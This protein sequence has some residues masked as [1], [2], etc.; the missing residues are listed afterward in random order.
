M[1]NNCI[2]CFNPSDSRDHIPSK[3]LFYNSERKKL[4]TV[5]SCKKCNQKYSLDE[6]FFR[7]FIVSLAEE[8]SPEAS[9]LF[10]TKVK[11]AIERRPSLGYGMLKNMELVDLFTKSGLYLGKKTKIK[12]SHDDWQ[13][14]FNVID[15]CVRGLIYHEFK[16]RL[17]SNYKIKHFWG[18]EELLEPKIIQTLKW[19]L[20][21]SEVF[22][23]GYSRLHGTFK[24]IWFTVFYEEFFFLSFVI[25]EILEKK[26]CSSTDNQTL[27]VSIGK[28]YPV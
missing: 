17:P 14:Y 24:S 12:I 2:Y 10:N 11:R 4:I 15:K 5:P 26:L 16:E 23:F 22:M 7:N 1:N 6:E 13:R 3:A 27:S 28:V 9:N 19:N 25:D 8:K 18:R 20:D 21:N